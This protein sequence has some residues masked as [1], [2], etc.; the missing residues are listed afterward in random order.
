[1]EAMMGY[2]EGT[3]K[4]QKEMHENT[5]QIVKDAVEAIKQVNP[6][7]PIT[8]GELLKMLR[9][10]DTGFQLVK[11]ATLYKDAYLKIWNPKKWE[12]KQKLQK[13]QNEEEKKLEIKGLIKK[14]EILEKKLVEHEIK[15]EKLKNEIAEL[16]STIKVMRKER[17]ENEDT[18]EKLYGL[19]LEC[20]SVMA[21][22][23]ISVSGVAAT[24]QE[25]L[26][27]VSERIK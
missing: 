23:G 7:T 17:R 21:L 6:E 9:D 15:S 8:R 12:E 14:V 5:L 2:N 22:K 16:T 25:G 11:P 26:S 27:V 10:E 24:F 13:K 19:V 18:I 1:M 20:D 3:K 4:Y